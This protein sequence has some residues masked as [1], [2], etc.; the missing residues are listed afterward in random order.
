MM[1]SKAV[2][3]LNLDIIHIHTPGPIGMAGMRVGKKLKIPLVYT[4]HTRVERYAQYYLH[5]PAWLE[6][7]TLAVISKRFYNKHNFVIAPSQGIKNEIQ[8][9]VKVPIEVIPTGVDVKANQSKAEK[10]NVQEIL[11]KY[12]LKSTDDLFITAS[13]I[14]KEKNIGFIIDAFCKIKEKCPRAKFLIAGG[15]P[16]KETFVK[17]V[18]TLKYADDIIFLGFLHQEELFALYKVAKVFL[19]SSLTETQGMVILEAMTMGLPVVALNAIGV[20]DLM[21]GNVGGFMTENDLDIF[22][23]RALELVNNS[24]LWQEKKQQA[25]IQAENFSIEK[26]GDKVISIYHELSSKV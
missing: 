21:T 14:G 24:V 8:K 15:G 26:M 20:E 5:L 2:A 1:R 9:Y 23:N 13:R 25:L 4:Y 12:N 17:Y 11:D 16:E 18:K 7:G 19:F 10:I 3:K 6:K 22:T